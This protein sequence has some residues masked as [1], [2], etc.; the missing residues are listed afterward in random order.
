LPAPIRRLALTIKGAGR[1][2]LQQ[3][4]DKDN[5]AA[6]FKFIFS[7]V[8]DGQ[9]LILGTLSVDDTVVPKDTKMIHLTDELRLLQ[10]EQYQSVL[11]RIGTMHET[12]LNAE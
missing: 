6:I 8:L 7:H 4:Q 3:E 12:M 10:R 11:D 5:I 2:P 1:S 9:Q